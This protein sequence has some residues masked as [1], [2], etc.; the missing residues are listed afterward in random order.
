MKS[1]IFR[2]LAV[3][4]AVASAL[5]SASA[6]TPAAHAAAKQYV[7]VVAEGLS[8]QVLDL[9]KAYGR[10]ADD[11]AEES[12]A[13][14][15]LIAGGK[16]ADMG[17]DALAQMQGILESAAKSGYKTGLVTTGDLTTVAPLFYTLNGDA[18]SALTSADAKYDFL[19]GGGRAKLGA[20]VDA[21]IKAAG[22]TYLKDEEGLDADIKGRVL[23]AEADEDL[24]FA[25]DRNPE[26]QA[27][28]SELSTLAMD[29]LGAGD[30]P[31]VLVIHD[32]LIKK[33]LD[34]KDSPALVEQFRELNS[35]LADATARRDDNPNLNLAVLMTGSQAT[36]RFSTSV[37][38]EQQNA[39]FVLSNLSLSYAG[40][41]RALK[42]ADT[43]AITAFADPVDGQY[44]GW[45][46][47][48]DVRE[49]LIAGTIDPE[50]AIR[51]SYE[52]ALK[53]D[54]NGA[55][56]AP[57]AYTLG[58]EAP[59]GLVAALKSAVATPAK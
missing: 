4:S 46:V 7:V 28:L 38:A 23:A 57:V 45:K 8:P 44:K 34:S 18:A 52:P 2:Q 53:L 43:D 29:T 55:A 36:P 3:S 26:E 20:D 40:A 39:L 24:N 47:P 56:A 21:K 49:R 37:E 17:A 14:D 15:A 6:F 42:G 12:T 10:K 48:A 19:A 27:G 54:Y 5:F 58:F 41:A 9:G 11:D 32:T 50:T 59:Q 16:S 13:F 25:I 30:S 1:L 33:A 51:A 31:F 35:I 22:G